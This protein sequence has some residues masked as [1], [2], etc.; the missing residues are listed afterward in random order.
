MAAIIDGIVYVAY[1]TSASAILV[2]AIRIKLQNDFEAEVKGLRE[3]DLSHDCID[4][5]QL[6]KTDGKKC[7]VLCNLKAAEEEKRP[8]I[9]QT[10]LS[11]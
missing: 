1:L 5:K 9:Q 7:I 11:S 4:P 2:T 3:Y 6:L 10:I 8:F